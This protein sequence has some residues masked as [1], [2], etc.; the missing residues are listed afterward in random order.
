VLVVVD[1]GSVVFINGLSVGCI[2]FL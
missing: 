2:P 1:R